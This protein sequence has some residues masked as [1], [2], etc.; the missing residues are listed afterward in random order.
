MKKLRDILE[1]KRS[2]P[3]VAAEK[4]FGDDTKM[5]LLGKGIIPPEE[6]PN[7]KVDTT[8][9]NSPFA[10]PSVKSYNVTPDKPLVGS[11]DAVG[12]LLALKGY[13]RTGEKPNENSKR[14]FPDRPPAPPTMQDKLNMMRMDSDVSFDRFRQKMDASLKKSIP[15]SVSKLEPKV[16]SL[17]ATQ[18]GY[19]AAE[20]PKAPIPTPKPPQDVRVVSKGDTLWDI[21]GGDP[22]E[23]KR[24]KQLN[25]GLN[26]SKMPVGYKLKL[27]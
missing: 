14:N 18:S 3:D 19:P 9:A 24:L 6:N 16:G 10:D 21:A 22:K 7:R 20:K 25:P 4:Q 1:Q 2:F 12:K 5:Q 8:G 13:S 17:V 11:D 23:V 27:K 26:P 15:S